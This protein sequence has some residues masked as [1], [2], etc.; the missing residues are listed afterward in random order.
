MKKIIFV[1]YIILIPFISYSQNKISFFETNHANTDL[2]KSFKNYKIVQAN[3][4]IHSITDG[5]KLT[6]SYLKD[7]SFILKENRLLADNYLVSI[8]KENRVETKNIYELGFDGKYY[9]NDNATSDN[10]IAFSIFETQYTIFIKSKN[11]EFY[12]EPLKKFD[13]TASAD[14]YVYYEVKDIISSEGL[15]CP[16]E[17]AN[18]TITNPNSTQTTQPID[19]CKTVELNFCVDYSFFITYSSINAVINRTLEVL[20]LTQLDYSI[21]NGLAYDVNFKV[22]RQF[23]I[24]CYECNY[25][26]TTD[27]LWTNYINFQPAETY[28]LMFNE[29]SAIRV[30]WQANVGS[31]EYNGLAALPATPQCSELSYVT[32]RQACLKNF[33]TQ[34]QKTRMVLSHEFGHSF[35]AEHNTSSP[36]IMD[37]GSPYE[38]HLWMNNTKII[39]NNSLAVSNCYYDCT[40]E[41]CTNTRVENLTIQFNS[42]NN[43]VNLNWLSEFGMEYKVRFYSYTTS[44]WTDFSTLNYPADTIAFNYDPQSTSCRYKIEIIP[45]CSGTNGIAN[46]L[47]FSV[48]LTPSPSIAFQSVV[49]DE[50]LCSGTSYTFV[51]IAENPGGNPYYQWK[52]NN[53]FV[54][55][56]GPTYTTSTL[57]NNNLLSCTITNVEPCVATRS[58]TVSKTV[59][60]LPQPC[61][62][63]ANSSFEK[64]D[65]EFFPNPVKDIFTIKSGINIERISI[66]N[67][68]GQ[69][70]QE[71]LIEDRTSNLDFS[72]YPVS[73]YLVKVQFNNHSKIIKTI[74]M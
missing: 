56:G 73:T 26:P 6:L 13:K 49:Q 51:V 70:L 58:A 38:G 68:L 66:Y 14:Y 27:D 15:N 16:V 31:N 74:K 29:N 65:F 61:E 1:F 39:I 69:K 47:L 43:L 19:N 33:I 59:T 9:T 45:V 23:I 2:S 8:K 7:Y 72:S 60:V 25:W 18:E 32:V 46:V 67:I 5:E 17:K 41:S 24:T 52:I 50:T 53:S 20:N 54:F 64:A 28:R 44:T 40:V 71:T 11:H 63:L 62:D 21:A 36:N 10:Q 4:D 57:Q 55:G 37:S 3:E 42:T 35:G 30:F 22:K 48:P 34:T 12:I